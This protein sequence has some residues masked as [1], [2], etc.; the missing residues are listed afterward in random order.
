MNHSFLGN[1]YVGIDSAAYWSN[2]ENWNKWE[3]LISGIDAIETRG[4]AGPPASYW[5]TS[6]QMNNANFQKCIRNDIYGRATSLFTG[7]SLWGWCIGGISRS[8]GAS[9]F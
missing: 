8:V 2:E 5:M 7:F 4:V 1:Q 3:A 6:K 9:L